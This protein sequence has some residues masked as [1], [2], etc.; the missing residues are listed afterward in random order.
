MRR[1]TDDA[2]KGVSH[3]RCLDAS[4]LSGVSLGFGV[5]SNRAALEQRVPVPPKFLFSGVCIDKMSF[6]DFSKRILG[7]L[8]MNNKR[9]LKIYF[10]ISKDLL[11]YFID[12]IDVYGDADK[13][14]EKAIEIAHR[15]VVGFRLDEKAKLEE[16]PV[17]KDL[18]ELK[19]MIKRLE[20]RIKEVVSEIISR[21]SSYRIEAI[22]TVSK[23]REGS[24]VDIDL[25]DLTVAEG[26]QEDAGE[27]GLSLEDAITQAIVVAIDE[28]L[29]ELA[30]AEEEKKENESS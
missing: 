26:A 3:S 22:K 23:K 6:D 16:K 7:S 2:R 28:E 19:D 18:S 1:R 20:K 15:D 5:G 29:K 30:G 4:V 9:Y 14:I 11:D 24:S 27:T 8:E 13:A 25:P 12:L 10:I 17:E 21:S